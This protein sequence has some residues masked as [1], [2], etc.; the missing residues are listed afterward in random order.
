M[1]V[2][3]HDISVIIKA[4]GK[5][6]FAKRHPW[7]S[8]RTHYKNNKERMDKKIDGFIKKAQRGAPSS[9]IPAPSAPTPK[10]S[11]GR[12]RVP[13]SQEDDDNLVEYLA[14]HARAG[15]LLGEKFW[16]VLEDK[17]EDFPWI[18]R[19]PWRSW[20][21]RYKKNAKYFNWAVRRYN[22]G[23]DFDEP[24]VQRP[25][26]VEDQRTTRPSTATRV[27]A[28][29]QSSKVGKLSKAPGQTGQRKPAS[30]PTPAKTRKRPRASEAKDEEERSVK[31]KRVEETPVVVHQ[32]EDP[33]PSTRSQT[34]VADDAEDAQ[35]VAKGAEEPDEVA[36]DVADAND[37]PEDDARE[38]EDEVVGSDE[39]D[40][41]AEEE[42]D[43]PV[44]SDD[45]RNEIFD[46][47]PVASTAGDHGAA[48][49]GDRESTSDES[50]GEQD[51]LDELLGDDD[52]PDEGVG[53]AQDKME[54]DE[55][56]DPFAVPGLKNE[57][58][59]LEMDEDTLEAADAYIAGPSGVNAASSSANRH[60]ESHGP[61]A[62]KPNTRIRHIDDPLATPELSPTQE[63]TARHQDPQPGPRQHAKRIK[64]AVET[65]FFGTP[66]PAPG[67][68]PS[69]PTTEAKAR[70][71]A[72]D[73]AGA[74]QPPRLV[75]GPFNK[76]FSDSRG[77]PRISPTGKGPRLSGVNFED[78]ADVIG[79]QDTPAYVPE[80][81]E[82]DEEHESELAQWPPVRRKSSGK[83][84]QRPPPPATPSPPGGKQRE[85]TVTTKTVSVRTVHTVER[86]VDR[87]PK[88]TP[89]P[90]GKLL[91]AAADED[92]DDEEQAVEPGS[93]V[94]PPQR[95]TQDSRSPAS[96][97]EMEVDNGDDADR[98]NTWLAQSQH[99]PFSQVP[100]PF[101]QHVAPS[102]VRRP[103]GH[104]AIP[105]P[106]ADVSRFQRLL[107]PGHPV[108]GPSGTQSASKPQVQAPRPK[109][110]P[111]GEIDTARLEELLRMEGKH[112]PEPSKPSPDS[113]VSASNSA[114]S[115]FGLPDTS[116]LA[117]K[118]DQQSVGAVH[119]GQ[120]FP[121]VASGS[122][123]P[124]PRVDKGKG[125][126][127]RPAD[128]HRR[129]T[130][131]QDVFW[132][133]EQRVDSSASK[134]SKR[135]SLPSRFH[136]GDYSHLAN[137]SALSLAFG[138]LPFG[139]ARTP[140]VPSTMALSRSV[141][142]AKSA[143]ASL[144]DTLPEK[145]L[146]MVKELGMNTALH[147]MAI[148]HGFN[149][150]TVRAVYLET[151]SLQLADNVLRD[152]REAANDRA[153]EALSELMSDEE[154]EQDEMQEDED[155]PAEEEAVERQLTHPPEWPQDGPSFDL[156]DEA[157]LAESSR[158]D[159]SHVLARNTRKRQR[160]LIEPVVDRRNSSVDSQY[161]PPKNTRAAK[162]LKRERESLSL[163]LSRR[164]SAA[165]SSPQGVAGSSNGLGDGVDF[166]TLARLKSD[167]WR[168]LE[169][170]LGKG[171]AKV[172]TGK[173]LAKFLQQ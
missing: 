16:Q 147:I 86:R 40:E 106:K 91:A 94:S 97:D 5:W 50:E 133:P 30:P 93:P 138:A 85:R 130:T 100:H 109:R 65:D 23:D 144:V 146:E 15:S 66:P 7:Q 48:P 157:P 32:E 156:A 149:E 119:R 54:V 164:E 134:P 126:A 21:E 118:G 165:A 170:S 151:G 99:H 158:I 159:A 107:D 12:V 18:K 46:S 14:T 148:N 127:D 110:A 153:S 11:P 78:E 122:R 172:L 69:S 38:D 88:G 115:P 169:K 77:R 171:G 166:G 68:I 72:H 137:Y 26:T 62:R 52:K 4:D 123:D 22:A 34:A 9:Q 24:E 83:A 39:D 167:D 80:A 41:S 76:A 161:S 73:R 19:H 63:A 96:D 35:D 124:A 120:L 75:E 55:E 104:Y 131:A 163:G 121:S 117:D 70:H 28:Q 56:D 67:R 125:R 102:P 25:S 49:A 13:Y 168:K 116:P 29:T 141:S 135:R 111:L 37:A 90:R 139:H 105:L 98:D 143:N 150:D 33:G 60:T 129:Y 59:V 51:E 57:E 108:A 162:H 3:D 47:P 160:L 142:P 112:F 140:S 114:D 1:P 45:Y 8:W 82:H 173:S 6:P 20:R 136:L 44:G 17:Q 10:K 152:M 61:P 154:Q 145:E 84:K 74:R 27:T 92:D 128:A 31:K 155:A 79:V 58:Q 89:F 64:R 87:R 43:G 53:R 113:I 42:P 101:S 95:E 36:D 132:Q 81:D 103:T 71:R 2:Y